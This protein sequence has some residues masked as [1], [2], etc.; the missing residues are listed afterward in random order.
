MKIIMG[1]NVNVKMNYQIRVQIKLLKI[2]IKIIPFFKL[3]I[4]INWKNANFANS[5]IMVF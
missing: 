1:I 4:L 5:V 3:K 2:N